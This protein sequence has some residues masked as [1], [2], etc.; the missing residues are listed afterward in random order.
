[1]AYKVTKKG[2][3]YAVVKETIDHGYWTD[4]YWYVVDVASGTKIKKSYAASDAKWY[5]DSLENGYSTPEDYHKSWNSSFGESIDMPDSLK[6]MQKQLLNPT[7]KKQPSQKP[8]GSTSTSIVET[9]DNG[10][11]YILKMDDGTF[12]VLVPSTGESK[13]GLKSLGGAKT[14][15][16]SMLKKTAG[17]KLGEMG[18]DAGSD[19]VDTLLKVYDD[20]VRDMYG[21]AAHEMAQKQAKY[22]EGFRKRQKELLAKVDSGEMT[23]S[24]YKDWLKTQN[25]TQEWYREMVES[26][27]NDLVE[28]DA[29]AMRI[30]NGYVPKAYAENY[31]YAT[32][33]IEHD[34]SVN[35]SFALYNESTVARL[36]ANPEG[37]LLPELPQPEADKLKDKLWSKRKISSAVTQSILQGESVP[38][39]AK[40]LA[41]VVGM[42]A[43][44]AMRAARTTLTAAQNLGRLDS[45]R[46]AK[47]MGIQLKKQWIATVDARTRYSHREIDRETV[48][49][50]EDFSNGCDCPAHLNSG[51]DVGEVYNCFV[52]DTL[53][54]TDTKIEHGYRRMYSGKLVTIKTASGVEFTCTPNHPILTV[55]G[56]V[57]AEFL[58]EGD[59]L[60]ITRRA[61]AGRSVANP[62]V[63]HVMASFETVYELLRV[64]S[65]ERRGGLGV[66][67]HG[68]GTTADIEVVG[69]ERLLRVNGDTSIGEGIA[70]LALEGSDTPSAA[71]S[72]L[73]KGLIGVAGASS[74]GLGCGDVCLAFLDGELFH[75]DVHGIG[76][77]PMVDASIGE[78]AGHKL[79]GTTYPIGDG[80]LGFTREI[81]TDNII[82]VDISHTNGTHVYNLQTSGGYYFVSSRNTDNAIIAHNCRCAMRYVLPDHEYDDLPDKTKDGVAYEDWKNEHQ[83]KLEA[84]KDKLQQNLADLQAQEA[85]VKA[86]MPQNKTYSGIWKGDVTLD[87][88]EAKKGSISAKEDYY[89]DQIL[90]APENAVGKIKVEVA[91]KNLAKLHEFQTLGEQYSAAKDAV[92]TQ[93]GAIQDKKK[94]VTKKLAKIG[95]TDTYSEERKANA[96]RWSS[97]AKADSILRHYTSDAWLAATRDEQLGVYGYTAGSGMFNRP[98][99]G[100]RGGWGSYNYVGPKKVD[101]DYEGGK[102]K[103][104]AMTR[105]IERSS[106]EE[107]VWL[108]RGCGNEAM[109]SFFGL[110]FGS[111]RRMSDTEISALTGTSNRIMGFLSCGTASESGAGFGGEV[112]MR[113]YVPAGTQAV[114]AEPFSAYSGAGYSGK[115]WDGKKS[116]GASDWDF[117][118]EDETIIQR[119][120][121]YTCTKIERRGYGFYVE[122]EVHPEDGYDTFGQED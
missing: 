4:E 117:G 42:G 101:L 11:H 95:I 79:S 29:N 31:N 48:E 51:S 110:D 34:A 43:N 71:L 111:M 98:L 32:F 21:Q 8:I 14:S 80:L 77:I 112:D 39:A 30:L 57:G 25:A 33:Q 113:I 82:S 16:K 72:P 28:A 107:D 50:E 90:N 2:K 119:G 55:S 5:L 60:L 88:Y 52:G 115:N 108:R 118:S 91:K 47:Q 121:S 104:Q 7:T 92:G 49:I 94:A 3:S 26:L 116:Q 17:Q 23:S 12:G 103:I 27:S 84:Q 87:D 9:I 59:D 109:E 13:M 61:D 97:K 96:L 114:Y 65:S 78:H 76:A 102:K 86:T 74:G 70:E 64:F 62:D 106:F 38:D 20:R 44:S 85:Q 41:S 24:Q 122:M 89:L 66:D 54:S 46:R 93:L 120:A 35:T 15:A 69:E 36:I 40:R 19:A 10:T 1:M 67:F 45:G 99:S 83:T 81:R 63:H 100:F 22:M 53:V 37:S 68:D 75:S 73:C 56:W 58:H 6:K 105:F 18:V